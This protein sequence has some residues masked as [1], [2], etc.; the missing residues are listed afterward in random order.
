M[1][2]QLVSW[3][4]PQRQPAAGLLIVFIKTVWEILKRVWPF[5]LLMLFNGKPEKENR[6]ELYAAFFALF[7]IVNSIIKFYF[8]RFAI[9]ED[10]LVIKRG[11]LKKE[12]IVVPL[13]KIQT[14][15]IEASALHK[16]LGIVKLSVDTAGS[17][18]TEV[19]IDALQRPMAAALQEKLYAGKTGINEETTNK[20]TT[21]PHLFKL[22]TADLL[23]LSLS[24]NHV[25][26]FFIF[27][28]F[29]YG[30]YDAL[31]TI[32]EGVIDTATQLA[33]RGSV[34]IFLVLF[35]VILGVTIA[36]STIRIFLKFYGFS[37][38]GTP[39]GFYIKGGL[40][41]VKEQLVP[42]EKVQF[43]VWR[44]NWIRK[45]I[46]LW[47]LEYRVAGSDGVKRKLRVE[48]P[49]TKAIYLPPL[50]QD[51]H[52]IP[53]TDNLTPIRIDDSYVVRRTLIAGLFPAFVLISSSWFLWQEKSLLFLVLPVLVALK[54]YLF[55]KRFKA[56]AEVDVLYIDRSTY[57]T[58]MLLVK[59]HKLQTVSVQ[60][61]SFQRKKK[62][63][64]IKLYTA[65]GTITLP[66]IPVAAAQRLI[67]YALYKIETSE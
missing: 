54:S 8:F 53:E 55:Q 28:S 7:A 15:H 46:G 67:N 58:Y 63:A 13:Q 52:P 37:V 59:W 62:L 23:K 45:K 35:A 47:L 29:G 19:T 26:A 14:V 4:A 30:L 66:Y 43:I 64:T 31:K 33:P 27:L 57:G 42:F 34:I 1:E 20:Q 9:I 5:L 22:N 44:A 21:A 41:N 36:I 56:Y 12:T 48:V 18:K 16:I 25:E 24:A 11:W 2:Q 60:Q 6:Y 32:S 51:Y 61:N 40:T 39:L 50:L 17:S 65:S 3:N 10:E 38:S 49:V